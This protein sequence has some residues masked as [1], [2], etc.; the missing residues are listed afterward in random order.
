MRNSWKEMWAVEGQNWLGRKHVWLY[1]TASRG[2]IARLT[3]PLTDGETD[4]EKWHDLSKVAQHSVRAEKL[5]PLPLLVG[6]QSCAAA[7]E[8]S[9]AVP[10][11]VE[12]RVRV[13]P[14]NSTSRSIPK[15]T[16]KNTQIWSPV[17]FPATSPVLICCTPATASNLHSFSLPSPLLPSHSLFFPIHRYRR[18]LGSK[19]YL[20]YLLNIW[21][22]FSLSCPWLGLD[23]CP[24]SPDGVSILHTLS[25]HM[26]VNFRSGIHDG[27]VP[28]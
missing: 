28:Y 26:F 15:R 2:G 7:V 17:G 11:K 19:L 27:T 14:S 24:S 5:E 1:N 21:P 22:W 13:C 10:S 9:S 16:E 12:H 3:P 8:N 20:C 18:E 25:Q 23:E 6:M 4:A